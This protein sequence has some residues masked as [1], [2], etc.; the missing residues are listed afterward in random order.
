MFLERGEGREKERERSI[1][2]WLSLM[3]SLLGTSPATQACALTRNQ[4]SDPLVPRPV[5]NPLSHMSQGND[6][7]LI[8]TSSSLCFSIIIFFFL[9]QPKAK[10]FPLRVCFLKWKHAFC[11]LSPINLSPSYQCLGPCDSAVRPLKEPVTMTI[12]ND[13]FCTPVLS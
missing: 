3:R 9:E 13:I 2:V 5:L 1:N 8:L 10:G 4:T 11:K 6:A 7:F 12:N